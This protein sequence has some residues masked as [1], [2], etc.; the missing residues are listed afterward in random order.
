MIRGARAMLRA[1]VFAREAVEIG[2]DLIH[3]ATSP[4]RDARR[5][6]SRKMI[7]LLGS[8]PVLFGVLIWLLVDLWRAVE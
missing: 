1:I 6:E 8:I 3:E 5:T 4:V 7:V 2:R